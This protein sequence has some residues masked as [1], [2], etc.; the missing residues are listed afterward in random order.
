MFALTR[1]PI[2]AV[3]EEVLVYLG[4][5]VPVAEYCTTGSVEL[6]DEISR[7][8]ADRAAVLMAN[9]GLFVVARSPKHSLEL[10][11]LVELTAEIVWGAMLLGEIVPL[12]D[13]IVE[14]FSSYYRMGRGRAV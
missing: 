12:P 8:L 1:Q 9:H 2:P 7:Y 10:A 11:Q 3:I 4:G 6:A 5:D 14:R 13:D